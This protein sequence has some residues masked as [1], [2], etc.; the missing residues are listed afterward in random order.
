MTEETLPPRRGISVREFVTA[1][2]LKADTSIHPAEIQNAF[3]EQA[4]R[5]AH[6]GVLQAKADKQVDDLELL[7]EVTI[8]QVAKKL[9]DAPIAEGA[10]K[11]SE[12]QLDK[13]VMLHPNVVAVRRAINEAKQIAKIAK[14]G[15]IAFEQRKD[16]LVQLGA[17]ERKERDGELRLMGRADDRESTRERALAAVGR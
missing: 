13:D 2:M 3:L 10:K 11:P 8:S 5:A 12:A 9:R 17:H 15:T 4:S 1:D 16:M 14:T 6:Y 7:L